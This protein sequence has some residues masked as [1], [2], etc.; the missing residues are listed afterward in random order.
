MLCVK[1]IS[2]KKDCIGW[3]QSDKQ[4]YFM[5]VFYLRNIRE[6]IVGLLKGVN[7]REV[8]WGQIK[9]SLVTCIS[10]FVFTKHVASYTLK[11][12]SSCPGADSSRQ[13]SI[14]INRSSIIEMTM[15]SLRGYTCLWQRGKLPGW[16]IFFFQYVSPVDAKAKNKLLMAGS[17][18]V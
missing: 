7:G 15:S 13:V 3:S 6:I 4:V 14:N 5:W 8:Y 10:S 12:S 11:I 17:V 2:I 18:H 16:H 1:F 9:T